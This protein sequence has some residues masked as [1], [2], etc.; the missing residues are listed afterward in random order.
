[1]AFENYLLR[2][3]PQKGQNPFGLSSLFPQLGQKVSFGCWA[4]DSGEGGGGI[5]VVG[6]VVLGLS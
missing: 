5:S 4:F 6:A 1:M 3:V 2:S